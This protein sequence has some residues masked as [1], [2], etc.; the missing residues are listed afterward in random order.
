MT[1]RILA[2]TESEA[3]AV[4]S[5]SA[6]FNLSCRQLAK[7][8]EPVNAPSWEDHNLHTTTAVLE[9]M[10]LA[11][12]GATAMPDDTG[13]TSACDDFEGDFAAPETN[14]QTVSILCLN[15]IQLTAILSFSA[16]FSL[17]CVGV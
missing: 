14:K 15:G 12:A 9:Q 11:S 5:A 17:L 6:S 16:V 10:A 4:S 13:T 3:N 2:C 1:K 7:H 8:W